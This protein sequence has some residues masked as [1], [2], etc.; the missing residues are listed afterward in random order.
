[1]KASGR[2]KHGVSKSTML[3]L[4]LFCS[5]F[6]LR[7]VC[8]NTNRYWAFVLS[9]LRG[10]IVCVDPLEFKSSSLNEVPNFEIGVDVF[11]AVMCYPDLPFQFRNPISD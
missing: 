10:K 4:T 3:C 5:L 8:D 1:M 2:Q 7:P 6:Q 11:L 9:L